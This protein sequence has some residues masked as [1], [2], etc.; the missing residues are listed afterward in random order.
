MKEQR[1]FFNCDVCDRQTEKNTGFPYKEGWVFLYNFEIKTRDK[2]EIKM[3]NKHFCSKVCL[4]SA[5]TKEL[6]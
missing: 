2:K 6:K 4:L 1:N 3:Q 5:I